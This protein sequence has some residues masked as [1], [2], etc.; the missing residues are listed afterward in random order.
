MDALP[1]GPEADPVEPPVL[2]ALRNSPRGAAQ[3]R[4]VYEG[5]M[6][7]GAAVTSIASTVDTRRLQIADGDSLWLHALHTDPRAD[8]SVGR[9]MTWWLGQHYH[10]RLKYI[11]ATRNWPESWR[12]A[13]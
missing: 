6:L 5:T 3:A 7:R 13:T 10:P 1:G 11:C 12:R 8:D 9:W 4:V 2:S